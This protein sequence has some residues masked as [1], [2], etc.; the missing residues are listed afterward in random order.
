MWAR[1]CADQSL[2]YSSMQTSAQTWPWKIGTDSFDKFLIMSRKLWYTNLECVFLA[3]WFQN[4]SFDLSGHLKF[5]FHCTVWVLGSSDCNMTRY[6][7]NSSSC[8]EVPP[9]ETHFLL[10]N[11]ENY[12]KLRRIKSAGEI[13]IFT[14][15]I[16]SV[17]LEVIL[18]KEKL[19]CKTQ[20][21]GVLRKLEQG[22]KRESFTHGPGDDGQSNIIF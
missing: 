11:N 19:T 6:L 14:E 8:F 4:L 22:E 3:K 10:L 15:V 12:S 2:V 16:F 20:K 1:R 17:W 18:N 5:L 7:G 21:K 9:S 13:T